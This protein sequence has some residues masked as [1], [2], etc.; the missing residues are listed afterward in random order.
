MTNLSLIGR[1]IFQG[2]HPIVL[3]WTKTKG[4]L[5][6]G[7]ETIIF[8]LY[9]LF[10]MNKISKE[11][12]RLH[13]RAWQLKFSNNNCSIQWEWF[14]I[15]VKTHDITPSLPFTL[16]QMVPI[17]LPNRC[18]SHSI[19]NFHMHLWWNFHDF[20]RRAE[21]RKEDMHWKPSPISS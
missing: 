18:M 6:T 21:T 2:V 8:L 16:G 10:K 19:M 15:L 4:A 3:N 13:S 5:K 14:H 17:L 9:K 7:D 1:G 11:V 12:R 20:W